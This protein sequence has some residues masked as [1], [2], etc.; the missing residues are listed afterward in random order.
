MSRDPQAVQAVL[1]MGATQLNQRAYTLSL[2]ISNSVIEQ[3]PKN[4]VAHDLA[5]GAHVGLN[6]IDAARGS[7]RA[8]FEAAPEY[9]LAVTN[10]AKLEFFLGNLSAAERLYTYM[11]EQDNRNGPAMMA[12]S[13]IDLLRGDQDS[14]LD[15]LKK[16]RK[17]SRT[18][19]LAALRPVDFH[20][21]ANNSDKALSIAREL[22][23]LD[24]E[25]LIYLTAFGRARL[26]AKRVAL[27]AVTF[28][29]IAVRASKMKAADWLVR[30]VAWQMRALDEQGARELL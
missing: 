30:N 16:A 23:G 19:R 6:D 10:L 1:L 21:F 4:P 27:S 29:E 25:N 20:I 24:P 22:N 12:L 7:F 13:E 9:F 18:P 15:W 8:A 3:D 11:V 17:D 14:T 2:E 26:A 5:G 28:K